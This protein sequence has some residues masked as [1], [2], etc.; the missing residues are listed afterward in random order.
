[1][2]QRS[3][4]GSSNILPPV[5]GRSPCHSVFT[6]FTASSTSFYSTDKEMT[7][8]SFFLFS[9]LYLDNR[10]FRPSLVFL[11]S[12][13]D[14]WVKSRLPHLNLP[15]VVGVTE[16]LTSASHPSAHLHHSQLQKNRF[17]LSPPRFLTAHTRLFTNKTIRNFRHDLVFPCCTL[18][19][20]T[21]GD[22]CTTPPL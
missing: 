14:C 13:V 4:L 9:L 15:Q 2:D 21:F 1:M 10:D 3:S 11:H 18:P 17:E 5:H 16:E 19:T 22:Y 8:L 12:S 6:S 20:D 7:A